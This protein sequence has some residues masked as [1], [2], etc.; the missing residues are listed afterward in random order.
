MCHG[1]W[2]SWKKRHQLSMFPNRQTGL[3]FQCGLPLSSVIGIA[4]SSSFSGWSSNVRSWLCRWLSVH[5][6]SVVL[7]TVAK[8]KRS[9]HTVPNRT[10]GDDKMGNVADSRL[11]SMMGATLI[12]IGDPKN[13]PMH[14]ECNHW[15]LG[16]TFATVFAVDSDHSA[17]VGFAMHHN[18]RTHAVLI[19]DLLSGLIIAD[20]AISGHELAWTFGLI[21]ATSPVWS[22]VNQLQQC[23]VDFA[24]TC[25]HGSHLRCNAML[26]CLAAAVGKQ[27]TMSQNCCN[28]KQKHCVNLHSS[29]AKEQQRTPKCFVETIKKSVCSF[30]LIWNFWFL[31]CTNSKCGLHDSSN[32]AMLCT[33]CKDHGMIWSVAMAHIKWHSQSKLPWF[34]L[35]RHPFQWGTAQWL[36]QMQNRKSEKSENFWIF[37]T[38]VIQ[39]ILFV[40][41]CSNVLRLRLVLLLGEIQTSEHPKRCIW[42]ICPKVIIFFS[43][44]VWQQWREWCISSLEGAAREAWEQ[45]TE[46]CSFA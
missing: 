34:V 32:H 44:F 12:S 10:V 16:P 14:W 21:C 17:T 20:A 18:T 42:N 23:F 3:R 41:S 25:R 35:L 43:A 4:A 5:A 19:C 6:L 8:R 36:N 27:I 28:V 9:A 45:I 11:L 7:I 26:R 30:C 31:F 40:C 29:D 2:H 37:W 38:Q 13:K 1:T 39:W 33:S 46:S 24:Q 22:F 15:A